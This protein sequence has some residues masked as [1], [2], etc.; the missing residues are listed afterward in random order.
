MIHFG[1]CGCG[2]VAK[3]AIARLAYP[4]VLPTDIWATTQNFSDA[5][6]PI[7]FGGPSGSRTFT[8][9]RGQKVVSASITRE[10]F[11]FRSPRGY[12]LLQ[13][14]LNVEVPGE[15]IDPIYRTLILDQ[16]LSFVRA[17]I[18]SDGLITYQGSANLGYFW[19]SSGGATTLVG[20]STSG[21]QPAQL[22]G[23]SVVLGPN[24]DRYTMQTIPW[25]NP[26]EAIPLDGYGFDLLAQHRL[27]AVSGFP[28]S[29]PLSSVPKLQYPGDVIY[30][31]ADQ[32]RVDV[33][34]SYNQGYSVEHF[35]FA[36]TKLAFC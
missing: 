4:A 34:C 1:P 25:T 18:Y 2:S 14:N 16:S 15:P 35:D 33:T 30:I 27:G 31:D 21:S 24:S 12:W 11:P 29:Y 17:D 20:R 23:N 13:W 8:I 10:T 5:F 19:Q 7:T 3:A 6:G 32:I 28:I 22:F 26:D 9:Y 36:M